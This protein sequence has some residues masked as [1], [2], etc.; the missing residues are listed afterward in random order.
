MPGGAAVAV[1]AGAIAT[2]AADNADLSAVC[3]AADETP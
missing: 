2:G 3:G 1:R